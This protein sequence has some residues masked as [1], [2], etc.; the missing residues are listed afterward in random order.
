MNKGYDYRCPQCGT[1]DITF[2]DI[3]GGGVILKIVFLCN[4][5][6]DKKRFEIDDKEEGNIHN[7]KVSL[8]ERYP[9]KES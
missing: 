7:K 1:S 3:K 9:S 8:K 5:C 2:L 4:C 6:P